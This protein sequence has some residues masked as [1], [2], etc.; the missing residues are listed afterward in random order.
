MEK[1]TSGLMGIYQIRNGKTDERYIGSSLSIHNRLKKHM[2]DLIK[3]VHINRSLQESWN[4]D[5]VESFLFSILEL[6]G[7]REELGKREGN[8]SLPLQGHQSP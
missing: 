7:N 6:V 8:R 5:G 1:P 4:K 3:G 2:L